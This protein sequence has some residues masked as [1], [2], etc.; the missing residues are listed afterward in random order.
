MSGPAFLP[1]WR[2]RRVTRRLL[3]EDGPRGT[4][5]DIVTNGMWL[6]HPMIYAGPLL[7]GVLS[8]LALWLLVFAPVDVGWL[9]FLLWI[10]LLLHAG[11]RALESYMDVIVI[12]DLR[13]FRMRG[14]N[15]TLYSSMPL[16]RVVDI[17]VEQTTWGQLF[18]FAHFTFDSAS[19]DRLL[20]DVKFISKPWLRDRVIQQRLARLSGRSELEP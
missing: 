15:G 10:G 1:S 17:T 2:M 3:D 11:Y 6:R 12:T 19:G 13:I 9:F 7:E 8:F 14:L 20:R 5:E 16:K 18:G 4:S